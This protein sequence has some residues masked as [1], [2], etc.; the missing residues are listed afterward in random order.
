M[1]SFFP[2]AEGNLSLQILWRMWDT[3]TLPRLLCCWQQEASKHST[4]RC[5]KGAH[6]HCQVSS[7]ILSGPCLDPT[8]CYLLCMEKSF[9][10]GINDRLQSFVQNAV[11]LEMTAK[12]TI[13]TVADRNTRR[14]QYRNVLLLL[15]FY[16][17]K[18]VSKKRSS[19]NYI[20]LVPF[21]Q[22]IV[23]LKI[24]QMEAHE[25]LSFNAE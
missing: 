12:T 3:R 15:V 25:P 7:N 11:Q 13:L 18:H 24:C 20:H 17:Q 8:H 6:W 22:G 10:E 23:H 14:H 9:G 21:A 4:P 1:S 5:L 2:W 16:R 19:M